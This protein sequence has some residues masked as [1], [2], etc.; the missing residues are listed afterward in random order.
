MDC[1]NI[2]GIKEG[3]SK[4]EIRQ[5]YEKQVNKFNSLI[6]IYNYAKISLKFQT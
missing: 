2:L 6:A 1:F 3:A 5:A 4:E